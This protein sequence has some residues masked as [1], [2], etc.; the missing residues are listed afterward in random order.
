MVI[1][2]LVM[3]IFA[4]VSVN[5]FKGK[6]FYCDTENL[7]LTMKQIEE[8][9]RTKTDCE[10]YGGSWRLYYNNFDNIF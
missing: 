8:V 1:V 7:G 4:I 6:S 2:L 9:I 3:F 5:L 10:I